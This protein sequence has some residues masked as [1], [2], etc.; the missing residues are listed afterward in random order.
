MPPALQPADAELRHNMLGMTELGS[1]ALMSPDEPDQ[2]ERYRGS[3]GKP[4][5]ELEARIVD[6][7]TG[8]DCR[9]RR[10]RRAVVPGPD[11]DGGLLRPR[12]P[13]RVHRR[14]LVPH[15]RR[16]RRRRRGL[17][18]LPGPARRHDQ[19]RRRERVAARGRRRCCA[20]SPAASSRSS[21]GS[22]TPSAVR[23]SPRSWSTPPRP[24][25][26]DAL[27]AA[28]RERLSAYKVPRRILR[29]RMAEVPMLSSGKPDMPRV[30]ECFDAA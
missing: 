3:F 19:D 18:L 25:D 1:V 28:L 4:V 16:L 6:F 5:P 9:A 27:H 22:P 30:V 14:R 8:L 29:L 7:D 26:D 15:R 12:A 10:G 20:R 24:L 23:S 11:A 2:P 17:L 13:R 21:S